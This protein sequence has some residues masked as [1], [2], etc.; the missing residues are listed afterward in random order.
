VRA[1]QRAERYCRTADMPHFRRESC[2]PGWALVGDAASHNDPI[3]AL[4]TCDALRDAQLLAHAAG[5]DD[6]AYFAA[7]ADCDA[8]RR[9]SCTWPGALYRRHRGHRVRMHW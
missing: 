6:D 7:L 2:G 9:R 8:T 3:T 5:R 4:G 1:C